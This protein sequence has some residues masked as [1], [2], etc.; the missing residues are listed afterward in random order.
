MQQFLP[1]WGLIYTPGERGRPGE[2]P[3]WAHTQTC[4]FRR[5]SRPHGQV[6]LQIKG[7]HTGSWGRELCP[8]TGNQ[9]QPGL[10]GVGGR[11]A[12]LDSVFNIKS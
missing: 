7:Y 1:V 9:I 4:P 3:S 5:D 11:Q 12:T 8:W 10:N 6:V 2:L